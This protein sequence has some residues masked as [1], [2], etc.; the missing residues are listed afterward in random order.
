MSN[1]Y[2]RDFRNSN[3]DLEEEDR[4]IEYDRGQRPFAGRK[5]FDKRKQEGTVFGLVQVTWED[6]KLGKMFGDQY[7]LVVKEFNGDRGVV[8]YGCLETW[9]PIEEDKAKPSAANQ[10]HE[11]KS[12]ANF[13]IKKAREIGELFIGFA[14]AMEKG[15]LML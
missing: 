8:K 6:R 10:I 14:E 2:Q 15:E 13:S 9:K 12:G 1:G 7:R 11:R 4:R 3:R 5:A